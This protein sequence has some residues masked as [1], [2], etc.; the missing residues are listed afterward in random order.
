VRGCGKA[1]RSGWDFCLTHCRD[2]WKNAK[3]ESRPF[4]SK[5]T[6]HLPTLD[7]YDQGL[8]LGQYNRT[9]DDPFFTATF[10]NLEALETERQSLR[11]KTWAG[12]RNKKPLPFE[13]ATP[14]EQHARGWVPIR[15]F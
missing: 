1:K 2:T 15:H 10:D 13:Q 7:D 11:F 4:S 6:G 5:P 3:D 14:S 8:T 9:P 12:I